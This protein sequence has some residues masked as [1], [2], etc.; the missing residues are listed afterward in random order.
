ML[1]RFVVVLLTSTVFSGF[2]AISAMSADAEFNDFPDVP[3]AVRFEDTFRDAGFYV[4]ARG[5]AVWADDT[6]FMITGPSLVENDY[7]LG[8]AGTLFVGFEVPD[9]YHGIGMRLEG[10][11]GYAQA[12]IDF[13][14][15]AGTPVT[16]ANSFGSTDAFTATVNVYADY[17]LGALRPFIG[18][19][20]G[21]ARVDFEGHGVTGNL[22][23]MDDTENGFAWQVSG[24]VGY[25]VTAAITVEAM[26]R[27]QEI[28]GVELVSATGPV[29]TIDLSSTQVLLGA[30]FSF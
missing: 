23:V 10:E 12:D 18:G 28:Q 6:Q 7:D 20:I 25:D 13:H 3:N 1:R 15:V 22:G 24:G 8:F 26:V 17:T 4:G 9:L 19:G 16:A 27:Y 21:V 11:L 5:G 2:S 30:R 14:T 29:S